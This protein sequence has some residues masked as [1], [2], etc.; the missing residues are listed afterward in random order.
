M[1]EIAQR[2]GR[3]WQRRERPINARAGLLVQLAIAFGF[4]RGPGERDPHR[5]HVELT[6][7]IPQK[8]QRAAHPNMGQGRRVDAND[9][10]SF[11]VVVFGLVAK[12]TLMATRFQMGAGL[13]L[14][15]QSGGCADPVLAGFRNKPVALDRR[16]GCGLIIVRAVAR[17][18]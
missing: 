6:Q 11:R 4:D 2:F 17:D 18:P 9:H 3:G 16:D 12:S 7:P 5:P 1:H 8:I 15:G 10:E 13:L 14:V